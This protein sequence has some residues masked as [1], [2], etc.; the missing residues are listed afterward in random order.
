MEKEYKF[1]HLDLGIIELN[2][3]DSFGQTQC[4]GL[5]SNWL[6]SAVSKSLSIVEGREN[7]LTFEVADLCQYLIGTTD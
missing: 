5:R 6:H 4:N 3:N 7:I 2:F 1:K